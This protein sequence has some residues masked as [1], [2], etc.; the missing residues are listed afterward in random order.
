MMGRKGFV[1]VILVVLFV[2]TCPYDGSA[3]ER[4]TVKPGDS[5]YS[6]SKSYGISIDALK[7]ANKLEGSHLKLNQ[8][9]FIPNPKKKPTEKAVRRAQPETEPYIV[10][11]GDSLYVLSKKTGLSV[12]EIKRMNQ[13]QADGLKTGQR[14]VLSRKQETRTEEVEEIG[15]GEEIRESDLAQGEGQAVLESLGK[16]KDTEERS[17]FIRVVKN[18]LGVPYR[19]GGST[20]KGIDCSAF[21]KKMF[22]IFNVEL[23]RTTREQLR[24]GKKVKREELEE[25]DVIFFK[26]QRATRTHVGIYIGNNEFIHASYRSKE[27]RVDNLDTPYFDK[28]FINGVRI[29]ELEKET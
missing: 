21:V 13:L 20:L 2:L 4:Y 16:W 15:D 6:I 17:L 9:L 19:L 3:E 12:Q 14:L 8:V 28:R 24:V 29:I 1:G 27:V 26:T 5:L 22:E 11:N 18:F 23:P 7:E 25:G 10:K